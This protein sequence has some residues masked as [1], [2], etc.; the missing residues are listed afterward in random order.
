VSR[1]TERLLFQKRVRCFV[2]YE[3]RYPTILN[4]ETEMNNHQRELPPII[5]TDIVFFGGDLKWKGRWLS[6]NLKKHKKIPVI[7]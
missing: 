6:E 5:E 3:K 4:P 1:E 2:E 7:T